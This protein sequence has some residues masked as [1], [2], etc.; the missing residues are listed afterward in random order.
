MRDSVSFHSAKRSAD[1]ETQISAITPVHYVSP[2]VFAQFLIHAHSGVG[3]VEPS[4]MDFVEVFLRH[5]CLLREAVVVL[6]DPPLEESPSEHCGQDLVG[7]SWFE[8]LLV[9][10][11]RAGEGGGV[12]GGVGLE[13]FG[14]ERFGGIVAQSGAGGDACACLDHAVLGLG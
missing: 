8:Q 7:A 10:L 12:R 3:G 14:V 5:A 6:L 4:S 1:A 13:R 2:Q 11:L 9:P